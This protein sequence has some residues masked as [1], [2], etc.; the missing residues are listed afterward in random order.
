MKKILIISGIVVLVAAGI[1]TFHKPQA[2]N[3]T[4]NIG[5]AMALTGD[6]AS[7]GE[8]SLKGAQLAIQ[9]INKDG[10]I[11]GKKVRLVVE[12]MKSSSAGS[13]SAVQKLVSIDG[14]HAI[15]GPSWI[16]VYQGA[17][18]IQAKNL[19]MISPDSGIEAI[20]TPRVNENIFS[21]WYRSQPKAEIL[22]DMLARKGVKRL[23]IVH[24]NDSYY[25]DFGKRL[26]AAAEKKGIEIVR[27]EIVSGG[28][29]DFKTLTLKIKSDNPDMLFFSLY[30][31]KAIDAFFKNRYPN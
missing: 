23:A 17:Q 8:M 31:Q 26:E 7:W 1:M 20:N 30:D 27:H 3:E 16:D 4:I 28:D 29:A 9:D 6:A 5:A 24:Q 22:A 19:I 21:T 10:G 14:I 11:H 18:G 13:L 12:D 25:V 2:I 15:L